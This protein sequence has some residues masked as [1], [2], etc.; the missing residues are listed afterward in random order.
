MKNFFI[1][2]ILFSFSYAK[3]CI[4][5]KFININA[6]NE[7]D[8]IYLSNTLSTKI[9]AKPFYLKIFLSQNN[10]PCVLD[11][12]ISIRYA[13]YDMNTKKRISSF[14]KISIRQRGVTSK[15]Y[16]INRAY[17]N[18]KMGFD[19]CR[20]FDGK[21][22]TF[23][24][25]DSCIGKCLTDNSEGKCIQRVYSKDSFAIRPDRFE[26]SIKGIQ[27]ADENFKNVTIKAL[28]YRGR[29][30]KGYNVSSKDLYLYAKDYNYKAAKLKYKFKFRNGLATINYIKYPEAGSI[31]IGIAEKKGKEFAKIDA[32][33]NDLAL[34]FDTDEISRYISSA[35]SDDFRV[36]PAYFDVKIL[37]VSNFAYFS[38][39]LNQMSA[40]VKVEVIAK[41][42]DNTITK[43]YMGDVNVDIS[44]SKVNR[45]IVTPYGFFS[46]DIKFSPMQDAFF[47]GKLNFTL[48]LNFNKENIPINEIQLKLNHIKVEDEDGVNGEANINKT[49]IFRY[50]KVK[51]DNVTTMDNDVIIPVY[52]MYYKDGKWLNNDLHNSAIYGS[53]IG[54]YAS[55]GIRVIYK[56]RDNI[57]LGL[58]QLFAT[59]TTKKRPYTGI[60]HLN[61]SPWLWYSEDGYM[62]EAP[63]LSNQDCNTHPCLKVYAI[64]P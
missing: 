8:S 62:Y 10:S 7:K 12:M 48:K 28:D 50:G 32:N 59:I 37:D 27:K 30:T 39:D 42:K 57:G 21:N 49:I 19:V 55:K 33:D 51:V 63:S 52:F 5:S 26:I 3:M 2:L 25:Y 40:K 36:I 1:F 34:S 15:K 11:K 24:D 47:R 17:K 43:N 53:V 14:D 38:N 35:W 4:D 29:L 64:K 60:V 41:S 22:Y 61:I 58:Q 44:H 6:I 54:G 46:D 18:V 56:N 13:L 23:Y 16:I 31:K 20:E 45:L 9:V